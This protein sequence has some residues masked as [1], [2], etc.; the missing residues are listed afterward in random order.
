MTHGAITHGDFFIVEAKPAAIK[1]LTVT[2]NQ[3]VIISCELGDSTPKNPFF[4]FVL[5]NAQKGDKVT[6]NWL[7]SS[8]Q[9]DSEEHTIT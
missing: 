4:V 3:K 9:S 7:D 2:L 5:K 8:G 1:V 6:V